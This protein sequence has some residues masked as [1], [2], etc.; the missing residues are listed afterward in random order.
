MVQKLLSSR[1]AVDSGALRPVIDDLEEISG[2]DVNAKNKKGQT[3]LHLAVL[4]GKESEVS[5]FLKSGASVAKADAHALTPLHYCAQ[6]IH[7]S[8]MLVKLL[9]DAGGSVRE[10]DE[11]GR[12]VFGLLC[13]SPTREAFEYLLQISPSVPQ[14]P[15]VDGW[16][17]LSYAC[18]GGGLGILSLDAPL[19]FTEDEEEEVVK[20]RMRVALKQPEIG[21]L[22]EKMTEKE[23]QKAA[24]T[25][26]HL[27]CGLDHLEMVQWLVLVVGV[28]VDAK[29]ENGWTPLFISATHEQPRLASF[30]LRIAHANINVKGPNGMTPLHMAVAMGWEKTAKE[31]IKF[32][33][34]IDALDN[35]QRT[36]L[37]YAAAQEL[38]S[39][40]NILIDAGANPEL[41]DARG[42]TPSQLL[43]KTFWQ[44]WCSIS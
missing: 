4:R 8:H 43:P 16:R 26:L 37:H 3:R 6:H 2:K 36:P 11:F 34:D 41:K 32:Q 14:A 27:A 9:V 15:D 31:M 29:D 7:K 35:A 44:T 42:W 12:T 23:R 40:A 39:L 24:I 18:A 1:K 30:L 5:S 28:D 33:T 38:V 20:E 10:R 21:K 17:P 22:V 13:I 19:A 25:A